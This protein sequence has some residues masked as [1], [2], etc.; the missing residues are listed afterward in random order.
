MYWSVALCTCAIPAIDFDPE[1]P[2]SNPAR[3]L[4]VAGSV[5]AFPTLFFSGS[6]Y[7][8]L[9]PPRYSNNARQSRLPSLVSFTSTC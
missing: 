9:H 3:Q 8:R 7:L 1:P 4:S 6:L 2:A 5:N